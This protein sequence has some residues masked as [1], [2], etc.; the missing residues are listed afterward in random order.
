ML[1]PVFAISWPGL[2]EIGQV[3]GGAAADLPVCITPFRGSVGPGGQ[4]QLKKE[5]AFSNCKIDLND[6]KWQNVYKLLTFTDVYFR[7]CLIVYN[8]SV[9]VDLPREQVVG[10]LVMLDCWYELTVPEKPPVI[11]QKILFALI[12]SPDLK[13]VTLSLA[14]MS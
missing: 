2:T 9:A 6:P 1:Y 10:K 7:H 3:S 12:S 11:G 4:I 13:P 8:G 5:A 14:G